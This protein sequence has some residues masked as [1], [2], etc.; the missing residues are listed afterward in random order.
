LWAAISGTPPIIVGVAGVLIMAVQG[1]I[2][3]VVLVLLL[4]VLHYCAV[5]QMSRR[6]L[7]IDQTADWTAIRVLTTVVC[8]ALPFYLALTIN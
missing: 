2:L 6:Y 4:I 8:L 3:D 1:R 7:T 5:S